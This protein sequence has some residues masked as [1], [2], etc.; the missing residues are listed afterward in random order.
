M[1]EI[2]LAQRAVLNQPGG[3][4]D[5]RP[6]R[7]DGNFVVAID[8]VPAGSITPGGDEVIEVLLTEEEVERIVIAANQE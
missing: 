4:T 3:V 6:I 5:I 1:A 8:M 7:G 2:Y